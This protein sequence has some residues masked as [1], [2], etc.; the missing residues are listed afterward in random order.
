MIA[1]GDVLHVIDFPRHVYL[2][3]LETHAWRNL[4]YREHEPVCIL[5]EKR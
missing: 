3:V 1:R 5:G 4:E 2:D